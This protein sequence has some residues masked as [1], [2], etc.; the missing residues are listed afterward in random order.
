MKAS[1]LGTRKIIEEMNNENSDY[2]R[3]YMKKYTDARTKSGLPSTDDTFIKYMAEDL[4]LG[5]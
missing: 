4:D 3:Q 2:S 5:F 1:I